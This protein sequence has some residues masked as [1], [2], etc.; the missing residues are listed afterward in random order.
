MHSS[1]FVFSFVAALAA[2]PLAQA[3]SIITVDGD[4]AIAITKQISPVK[5]SDPVI[6]EL[7]TVAQYPLKLTMTRVQGPSG[8]RVLNISTAAPTTEGN[9]RRQHYTINLSSDKNPSG[10]YSAT[11]SK[12]L[13]PK[14]DAKGTYRT[15]ATGFVVPFSLAFESWKTTTVTV[16]GKR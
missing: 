3:A 1:K 13:D 2:A 14:S 11:F 4:P 16:P 12:V 5:P 8:V 7:T 10:K 9:N 15:S 6:V